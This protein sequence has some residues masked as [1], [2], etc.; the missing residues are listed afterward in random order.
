MQIYM[1]NEKEEEEEEKRRRRD[2]WMDL[3]LAWLIEISLMF[4]NSKTQI[5]SPQNH[6]CRDC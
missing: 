2:G 4:L 6:R 3:L 5:L 1:V